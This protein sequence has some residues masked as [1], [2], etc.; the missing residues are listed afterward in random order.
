MSVLS[1]I[2]TGFWSRLGDDYGRKPI[3]ALFV[4]GALAM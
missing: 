3:L 2:T 4:I 1:A